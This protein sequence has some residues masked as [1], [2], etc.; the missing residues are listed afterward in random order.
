M[1]TLDCARVSQPS[2]EAVAEFVEASA[3]PPPLPCWSL[4]VLRHQLFL[5]L[6]HALLLKGF[7]IS[8]WRVFCCPCCGDFCCLIWGEICC[9]ICGSSDVSSMEVLLSLLWNFDCLILWSI[10]YCWVLQYQPWTTFF[11]S[12]AC[13]LSFGKLSTNPYDRNQTLE[14]WSMNLKLIFWA[15]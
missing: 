7:T 1:L 14:V 6:S 12:L 3:P 11:S 5:L 4:G 9:L 10:C 13:G 8:F 15:Y 2:F